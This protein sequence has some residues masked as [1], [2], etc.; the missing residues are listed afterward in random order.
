MSFPIDN[1]PP[2]LGFLDIG[3]SKIVCLM[4]GRTGKGDDYQVIGFGHQKSRGLKASVVVDADA[5]EDAVRATISQ[6][7]HMSGAPLASTMLAAACGR[8]SSTH[9][10]VSLD[11]DGSSRDGGAISV[12]DIDRLLEAGRTHAER[13][14]RAVLNINP[15]ATYIDGQAM[16][17]SAVGLRG[18][19]LSVDVHA[20]AADRGPLRHL[21]HLAE[22]C[23]LRVLA[24][25]PAPLASA[26]AV[27]TTAERRHGITIV[28]FG[29]GSTSLSLFVGGNLVC[30]H[31]FP[32]G[33]NHL[34]FDLMRALG[35]TITEAERIKKNYAIQ[36][37]AHP[38]QD[39]YVVYQTRGDNHAETTPDHP[40][41][42]P[43]KQVTRAAISTILT[44][45]LDTLLRQVSQRIDQL[46]VPRHLCGDV[47]LTGGGS[48]LTGLLP[49]A[50]TI[51]G[52]RVRLGA[53]LAHTG[54]PRALLHPA[55]AT[56]AGLVLVAQD[57]RLGLR[58]DSHRP[59]QSNLASELNLRQSF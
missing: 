16:P 43:T 26:L 54:L 42:V 22:R 9:V 7:E 28:E 15:L 5:A 12:P 21:L 4:L 30:A 32:I 31:V 41:A 20:I 40:G 47:V 58:L 2:I 34:T 13:D 50:E 46:A 27:S 49:L 53:P 29:A 38:A 45:R 51:M 35:T 59:V 44:S 19:R 3:T 36:F 48:V 56:V 57:R 23:Q 37:L 25:A 24:L 17:G 8:L 6:A 39:D 18:H 55:F 10:A 1:Q 33:S 14:D 52:G 11:L